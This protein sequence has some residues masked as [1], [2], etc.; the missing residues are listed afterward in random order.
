MTNPADYFMTIMSIESFDEEED[1][2]SP[3]GEAEIKAEY[4]Q[5]ITNFAT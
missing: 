1:G 3:K 5:K 2:K 4:T